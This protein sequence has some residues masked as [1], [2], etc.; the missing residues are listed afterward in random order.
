MGTIQLISTRLKK[1][2]LRPR[3][4]PALTS[5]GRSDLGDD[6]VH[7]T[8]QGVLDGASPSSRTERS[9][10]AD[11]SSCYEHVFERHNAV[12]IR[13]QTLQS[14]GGPNIELQHRII[15][16]LYNMNTQVCQQLA[17]PMPTSRIP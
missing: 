16:L 7:R 2:A 14:F 12:R 10:C 9:H 5:G 1:V 3:M 6:L 15:F 11:N 4:R 17:K 13:P 8:R